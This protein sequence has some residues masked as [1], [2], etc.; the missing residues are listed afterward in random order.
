MK[1][2]PPPI[3]P[4][5]DVLAHRGVAGY[6]GVVQV[7]GSPAPTEFS[8]APA[9]TDVAIAPAAGEDPES[10]PRPMLVRLAVSLGLKGSGKSEDLVA[11]IRALR[12]G[13]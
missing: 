13:A 1:L 7:V 11:A 8:P 4:A 12:A 2:Q 3:M 9:A 6:V 5:Q 10:L